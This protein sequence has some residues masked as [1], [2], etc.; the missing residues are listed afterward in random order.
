MYLSAFPGFVSDWQPAPPRRLGYAQSSELN[1]PFGSPPVPNV[2][3]NGMPVL[4]VNIIPSCQPSVKK[5][6]GPVMDFGEGSSHRP[7]ITSVRATLKSD[8]PRLALGLK[9]KLG[10][11]IEFP[12]AS[13]AT[14]AELVSIL[15]PQ[16]KVPCTWNPWLMR[17]A[18]CASKA[19]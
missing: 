7:L 5:R 9:K 3:V 12:N 11:A 19:L 2:G 18:N 17:F 1:V 4:A 8:R 10:L 13:P 15:R 16:V 6:A 14:V